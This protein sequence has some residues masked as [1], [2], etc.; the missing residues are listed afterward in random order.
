LR[1]TAQAFLDA[2]EPEKAI[3]YAKQGIEKK[4]EDEAL[5]LIIAEANQKIAGTPQE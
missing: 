2:G 1:D 5:Q 4:P 3:E